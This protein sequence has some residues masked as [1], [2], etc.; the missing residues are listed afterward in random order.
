V[1]I[2]ALNTASTG[3]N[4][5]ALG[6]VSLYNLSSGSGNIG[7]GG[8]SNGGSLAPVFNVTTEDNRIVMG[9]TTVTNA[10]I[11]V[12]WSVVSDARDK[13]EVNPIPHGLDFVKQLNP[14]SYMGM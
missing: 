2:S 3:S 14:I 6:A 4:N 8:F 1:G 7:I 9:T 13:A 5:T 10:Y 12:A 11:Q